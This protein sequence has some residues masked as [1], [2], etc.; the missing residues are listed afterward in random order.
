[1]D[2]SQ[3]FGFSET[4]RV[5][6]S[7]IGVLKDGTKREKKKLAFALEEGGDQANASDEEI[8]KSGQDVKEDKKN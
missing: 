5:G 8:S 3:P 6:R 2:E 4:P 1:M 7:L